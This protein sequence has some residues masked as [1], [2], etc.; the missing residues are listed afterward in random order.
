MLLKDV[1]QQPIEKAFDYLTKNSFMNLFKVFIFIVIESTDQFIIL[2]V[3]NL[4]YHY[5]EYIDL[6]PF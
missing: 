5:L 6:H 3:T 4:K 1:D 2:Q